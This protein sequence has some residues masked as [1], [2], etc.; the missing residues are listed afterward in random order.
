M[1]R[2]TVLLAPLLA[3]TVSAASLPLSPVAL[4]AA[5]AKADKQ[6]LEEASALYKQGKTKFE[7][8]EYEAAIEL[9]KEAYAKL[10]DSD[11]ARAIKT[12]LVYN[13]SEAQIR[14]YEIGRDPTHLRKAR[15]LL[16]DYLRNHEALYG[17]QPDA[18]KERA[19]AQQRLEEVDQMLESAPASGPPGSGTDATGDAESDAGAKEAELTPEQKAR[20]EEEAAKRARLEQIQNDPE[21]RAQDK[22]AQKR[23]VTGAVLGGIGLTFAVGAYFTFSYYGTT[24]SPTI[25]PLTGLEVEADPANGALVAGLVL[26]VAGL[27]LLGAGAGLFGTGMKKRKELR[28]PAGSAQAFVSPWAARGSGGATVLVR[29]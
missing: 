26:G 13:I 6:A 21:L 29:F 17:N 8:A 22:A 3:L 10:P 7:M 20:R 18:V 4:A 1:P 5:P 2:T 19:A 16:A 27:G 15:V 9:W 11:D 23:I 24:L 14:A 25:D 12:D 28:T